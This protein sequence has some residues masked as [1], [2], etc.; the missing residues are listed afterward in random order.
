MREKQLNEGLPLID[1]FYLFDHLTQFVDTHAL[2]SYP[3][4]YLLLIAPQQIDQ[5]QQIGREKPQAQHLTAELGQLT[6]NN[7]LLDPL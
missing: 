1:G 6:S 7:L 3:S 4:S 2:I 5:P